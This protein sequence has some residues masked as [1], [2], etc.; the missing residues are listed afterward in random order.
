VAADIRTHEPR[1][2]AALMRLAE[3]LVAHPEDEA[4]LADYGGL[5]EHLANAIEDFTPPN[6]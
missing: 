6:G 1:I 2:T 3:V 5:P 4:L